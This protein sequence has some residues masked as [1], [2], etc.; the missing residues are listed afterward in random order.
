M[1]Q[2]DA[3]TLDPTTTVVVATHNA[4]KVIEIEAILAPV[5]PGV[6]FVALGDL[7]DFPEPAETGQTFFDNATIK[8]KDAL[9]VS[10][11]QMAIADDSGICVDVL[12]G[13]P[14]IY[15]ARYAGDHGDDAANNQLLLDTLAQAGEPQSP[16][17]F[18][19]TV[20]FIDRWDILSADGDVYGHITPEPAGTNGFGYDPLFVPDGQGGRTMA[21]LSAEEKNAISHRGVAL[22]AL[23]EKIKNRPPMPDED[24]FATED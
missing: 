20:V 6:R 3:S 19:S 22:R 18:H 16:A 23:A 2:I 10:G 21:E 11:L 7:G 8:A 13:A 1:S 14:G 17:H 4:H 5:M 15:S 12:D 24:P 9:D